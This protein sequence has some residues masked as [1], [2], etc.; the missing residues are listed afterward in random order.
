MLRNLFNIFNFLMS[1]KT[2]SSSLLEAIKLK[3]GK[4]PKPSEDPEKKL[5]QNYFG[6]NLKDLPES[7][8][9][10]EKTELFEDLKNIENIENSSENNIQ[11]DQSE[12]LKDLDD[13]SLNIKNIS[14]KITNKTNLKEINSLQ[15]DE[16]NS[17]EDIEE[18]KP[19]EQNPKKDTSKPDPIEL[20]LQK[21]EAE[22]EQKKQITKPEIKI[23]NLDLT[24]EKPLVNE[25]KNDDFSLSIEEDYSQTPAFKS[26]DKAQEISDLNDDI[27]SVKNQSKKINP[28]DNL[29]GKTQQ[30]NIS[31]HNNQE[32]TENTEKS[33]DYLEDNFHELRS[34]ISENSTF[35]FSP[36]LKYLEEI[37]QKTAEILPPA[38]SEISNQE[39]N[40]ISQSL[41]TL[42][43]NLTTLTEDAKIEDDETLKTN[44][45]IANETEKSPDFI[46]SIDKLL[47]NKNIDYNQQKLKELA[48]LSSNNNINKEEKEEDFQIQ[49]FENELIKNSM[50]A[51][52]EE[53]TSI[54]KNTK[55][56]EDELNDYRNQI[57]STDNFEENIETNPKLEKISHSLIHE[58]TIYQSTNSI[59]KL[60]EAKDI[61]KKINESFGNNELLNKIAINLME[62]KL[63][64][65]LN[66]NLPNLVEE[67][68]RKEI[69]KIIPK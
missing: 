25:T 58:E 9:N 31:P 6:E 39:I 40:E 2:T 59:K 35:K 49:N 28:I 24:D 36:T 63:E 37:N 1:E 34:R 38:E 54:K 27:K 17:E 15:I 20:E 62:P 61:V 46:E 29:I 65:W 53:L 56:H 22:L 7:N 66:E 68:V 3:L 50:Q 16:E 45:N 60:I 55:I 32:I 21:L 5:K 52:K 13:E 48:D 41:T 26:I 4:L 57:Q 67:I 44:N 14:Q 10:S 8:D 23:E 51:I 47:N 19:Q 64:K 33:K 69:E 11:E 42:N 18:I 43:E 12:L 30:N